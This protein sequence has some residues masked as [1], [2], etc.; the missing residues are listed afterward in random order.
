[1]IYFDNAASTAP[2]KEVIEAMNETYKTAWANPSSIHTEGQRARVA[3]ENAR[4]KVAEVLSA[5]SSE[6]FFTS[7]ATEA[8]NLMIPLIVESNQIQNI[9][10][11][12]TEHPAILK[13]LQSLKNI[14]IQY[15]KLDKNGEVELAHLD[16]VLSNNSKKTLVA[17]MHAN[18][19]IGN[20]LPIKKVV[21]ICKKHQAL[22][23][24]DM[25]Q[26]IGKYKVDL[27]KL[28]VDFAVASAHKFHGPKGNGIL[29]IK[30]GKKYAPLL[31]GGSQERNM[32]SGT[33]NI[34]GIV[35]TAKAL[36]EF[37]KHFEDRS[38]HI[39][40]LK[41]YC[42]KKLIENFPEVSFN[43]TSQNGGLYNLINF[44]LPLKNISRQAID[45]KFDMA[46]I[47]ISQGS[48][49]SSGVNQLS[50]IVKIVHGEKSNAIRV[51][52]SFDNKIEEIDKFIEVIKTK[53]M[54]IN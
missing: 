33:E 12:H 20:L 43:G 51:S 52:L 15:V 18:N 2:L 40:N 27:E 48:A 17:L 16:E 23:F 4:D 24:C 7:S 8:I 37:E 42:V 29:Y 14:N 25:V 1:M 47:A 11:S 46:G 38:K 39:E 19:E 3:I 6:I 26:T 22:F 34:S 36:E 44:S 53:F 50:E 41:K 5:K 31:L 28:Q 32:R 10:T 49:C 9:I 21:E 45:M 54:N 13:T 30:S 35:G